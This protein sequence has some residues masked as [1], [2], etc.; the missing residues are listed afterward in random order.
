MFNRREFFVVTSTGGHLYEIE[1]C[2]SANVKRRS[3]FF[4]PLDGK[5]SLIS[6]YLTVK[7]IIEPDTKYILY[8]F[9]F[10]QAFFWVIL[11]RPKIMIS[12]GSG[13]CIPFFLLGKLIGAKLIYIESKSRF[14]SPSKTAKFLYYFTDLFIIQNSSL[15]KFFTVSVVGRMHK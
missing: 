9:L 6:G 1:R 11:Y 4:M 15:K 8:F 14:I 13:V 12:A 10:F 3:V 2:L 5:T 7:H